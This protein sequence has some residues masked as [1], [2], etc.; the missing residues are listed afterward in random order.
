MTG[1]QQRLLG[2]IATRL[3][4]GGRLLVELPTADG[5]EQ[6]LADFKPTASAPT[7]GGYHLSLQN[8]FG[9]SRALLFGDDIPALIE[10]N[11]R[12]STNHIEIRRWLPDREESMNR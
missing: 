7:W 8:E 11:R 9:R 2:R 10:R 6:A 3:A 4:T 12:R 1:W 5:F